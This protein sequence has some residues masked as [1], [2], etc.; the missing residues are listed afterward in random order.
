MF[1]ISCGSLLSILMT[2]EYVHFTCPIPKSKPQYHLSL[3]HI[4]FINPV[5]Y[6]TLR[7]APVHNFVHITRLLLHFCKSTS[8]VLSFCEKEK[9]FEF[10]F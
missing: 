7:L 1:K 5:I 9:Y 8:I 6:L 2:L 3:Y 10:I 4:L